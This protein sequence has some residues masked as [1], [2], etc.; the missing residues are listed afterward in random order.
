MKLP[1]APTDTEAVLYVSSGRRF[2]YSVGAVS[3]LT[4]F[5]AMGAFASSISIFYWYFGYLFMMFF[6]LSISYAVS[7]G[8]RE[9][10][11]KKHFS[12]LKRKQ[13]AARKYSIDIYLPSCGEPIEI[14]E[15]TFNHVEKLVEKNKDIDIRV[16]VLDDKGSLSVSSLAD[17]FSFNYISRPNKGEHKKAGN[18]RYAFART[19][20]DFI[21]IFDAD[22]CPRGDFLENTLPYMLED[23]RIAILQTPQFFD[24]DKKMSWV[25]Y[26][27]GSVQELFYRLIQPARDTYGGAICV[28]TNALYRRSALEPMGGTALIDYSED[29]HTGFYLKREGWKV[30]YIPIILAKG[31][32]PDTVKS[33]FTQQ[34]R[35][36]MGSISLFMNSI[37]WSTKLTIMQRLSYLSGMFYYITTGIG[38]IMLPIPAI[39]TIWLVPEYVHWYNALFVLPSFFFGTVWMRLWSK[40]G[41]NLSGM[42]V[43]VVMEWAHLFALYDKIIGTKIPWV[44]TG[45]VS[46]VKRFDD[47]K[48]LLLLWK[49]VSFSMIVGGIFFQIQ[50]GGYSLS[51]FILI[52]L[53]AIFHTLLALSVVI[54]EGE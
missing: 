38:V 5:V 1:K 41:W 22:F 12:I 25:E 20:G 7:F 42:R 32:C 33:F 37:F 4:L 15:N 29:V 10:D 52:Y 23:T 53:L 28:G 2:L 35:W 31:V 21:I 54:N 18:L 30:K 36:A 39:L 26:G 16:H 45:A 3:T 19:S 8:A 11:L 49:L 9:F 27:A 44:P 47:F 43:R 50:I 48:R 6:Y 13:A 14:I 46:K 17:R 51:R 40:Q 34:Y 24:T